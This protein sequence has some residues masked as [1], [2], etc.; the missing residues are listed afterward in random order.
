MAHLLPQSKKPH[1][2]PQIYLKNFFDLVSKYM[3]HDNTIKQ[4]YKKNLQKIY[5]NNSFFMNAFR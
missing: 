5:L 3:E 2:L 1:T 4:F